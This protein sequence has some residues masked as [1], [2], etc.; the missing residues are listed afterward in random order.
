MPCTHYTCMHNA[1]AHK[2]ESYSI[3]AFVRFH[4]VS[5]SILSVDHLTCFPIV[6]SVSSSF[7][8]LA[9]ALRYDACAA[10]VYK[11]WNLL[12]I[13]RY[14]LALTSNWT[15]DNKKATTVTMQF[16]GQFNV[17][18][19][20]LISCFC[21]YSYFGVLFIVVWRTKSTYNSLNWCEVFFKGRIIIFQIEK[22]NVI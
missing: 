11:I 15:E 9:L 17:K 4:L 13:F 3:I 5:D 8:S 2:N 6:F 18:V 20:L 21:S 16:V 14:S 7:L 1:R 12:R 22:F 19:F 10:R